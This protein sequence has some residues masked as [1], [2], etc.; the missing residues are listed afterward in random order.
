MNRNGRCRKR[1]PAVALA[2]L[3]AGGGA[4]RAQSG[5]YSFEFLNMTNPARQAAL[6]AEF[7]SVRD[8]DVQLA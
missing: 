3:L 5:G 1:W 4:V 6:G 8:A 2:C 7:L